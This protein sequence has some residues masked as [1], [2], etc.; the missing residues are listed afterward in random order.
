MKLHAGLLAALAAL[1]LSICPGTRAAE[2]VVWQIGDF[3]NSYAEFAIPGN[4]S[5]YPTQFSDDV[6]FTV[7]KDDPAKSWPFIHPGPMDGWAGSRSHQFHVHFDLPDQPRGTFT[8]TIDMVSTQPSGPPAYSVAI[9]GRGGEA[10]LPNGSSDAALA[11]PARGKEFVLRVPIPASS[12]KQGA[13]DLV[14]TTVRGSWLIYDALQFTNDPERAGSDV[15]VTSAT[16][17]PTTRFVRSGGKLRQVADL[18]VQ[19]SQGMA[20]AYA[21]V[22][23]GGSMQRVPLNSGLLGDANVEISLPEVTQPTPVRCAITCS[24][25]FRA[26]L[27]TFE[28]KP[29]RHWTLYVQPSTHV[30]IGY[31]DYQERVITRHDDNMSTALDLCAKHPDFR[32]NTEAAWVEDNY[33][34]LMPPDRKAEFIKYAREGRIGCQAI[35]G[36]MLTGIC[37]HEEIIRDLYYARATA[38]RYGIPFDIAMS[39]DVPTQVWTLPMILAGSGIRYFSA[40]LNLTRGDS[41]GRLFGK[42][43]FYWQGPDGSRVM[44]WLSP[45]YAQAQMLRL[46]DS[47]ERAAPQVEGF[48]QRFERDKYPYDAVLAFGGFSDNQ[49]L[50]PNLAPVVQQWNKTYAYPRIVLCRG[51][52]FF[53]HIEKQARGATRDTARRWRRLLGGRRGFIRRRNRHGP[54]RQGEARRRR[55]APFPDIDAFGRHVSPSRDH[56]R[57]AKRDP[58]RRAHVGRCGQHKRSRGRSDR[59]PMGV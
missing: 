29:Q 22:F 4:Y 25:Q 28:L 55:E 3:D 11:D 45:G 33:L 7:G 59:P 9:N 19:F 37:S 42:S 31:T 58:L 43:P 50:N 49:P 52:E 23:E 5:A 15:T 14:L 41:F 39:S 30:D 2:T 51:P 38:T 40:G 46:A 35:Y 24:G 21:V 16:L 26:R 44:T 53:K 36:N 34:S 54:N 27:F 56:Q 1:T 48:L 10:D 13:N 8:L 57:L 20:A 47:V 17:H 18:S 32:W 12:L 6:S